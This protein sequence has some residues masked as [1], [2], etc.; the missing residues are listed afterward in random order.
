MLGVDLKRVDGRLEVRRMRGHGPTRDVLRP[1][2]ALIAIDGRRT[3]TSDEVDEM[4]RGRGGRRS[5]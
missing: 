2:D 3:H 5:R 4:L 1:G